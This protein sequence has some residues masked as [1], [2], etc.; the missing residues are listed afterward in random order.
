MTFVTIT[1]AAFR[2]SLHMRTFL[3]MAQQGHY[4]D[5]NI[6]L[7]MTLLLI[8]KDETIHSRANIINAKKRKIEVILCL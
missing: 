5:R 8:F 2:L 3:L 4:F 1:C 6:K 7:R